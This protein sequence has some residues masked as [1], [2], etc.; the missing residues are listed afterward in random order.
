M[1]SE[2]ECRVL[3]DVGPSLLADLDPIDALVY[4]QISGTLSE[5]TVEKIKTKVGKTETFSKTREVRVKFYRF[6]KNQLK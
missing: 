2:T 6:P 4:F 5:S 1:L 3:S